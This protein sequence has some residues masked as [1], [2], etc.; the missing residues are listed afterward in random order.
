MQKA[1]PSRTHILKVDYLIN[2]RNCSSEVIMKG[3][4]GSSVVKS[5]PA[6]AGDGVLLPDLRRSHMLKSS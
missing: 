1:K 4:H 6:N 5:L 2:S 3:F